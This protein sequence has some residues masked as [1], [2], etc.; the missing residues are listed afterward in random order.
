M[1]V[2]LIFIIFHG[3]ICLFFAKTDQLTTLYWIC[4][5]HY[6]QLTLSALAVSTSSKIHSLIPSL[7]TDEQTQKTHA[8]ERIVILPHSSYAFIH[9]SW[10]QMVC[11]RLALVAH[12]IQIILYLWLFVYTQSLLYLSMVWKCFDVKHNYQAS[13]EC[14]FRANSSFSFS[15][16]FSVVLLTLNIHTP[17][18]L[19]VSF[20]LCQELFGCA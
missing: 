5:S 10:T 20:V 12:F 16:F 7:Y 17:L 19:L 4:F 9:S 8:Y 2:I 13:S 6:T 1:N 15:S 11:L 3:G 14:C 18:H